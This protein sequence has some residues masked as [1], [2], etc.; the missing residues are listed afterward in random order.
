MK[1]WW[2]RFRISL[3]RALLGDDIHTIVNVAYGERLR[4]LRHGQTRY[5]SL[6]NRLL[7]TVE[8]FS[9]HNEIFRAE[10]EEI[11]REELP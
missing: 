7:C 11:D 4:K 5:R 2:L 8:H 9:E 3:A 6:A 10:L 1:L